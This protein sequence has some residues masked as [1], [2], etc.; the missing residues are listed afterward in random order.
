MKRI[1]KPARLTADDAARHPGFVKSRGFVRLSAAIQGGY[2]RKY[3]RD[4]AARQAIVLGTLIHN[5][6]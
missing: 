6:K 2:R 5:G 4:D 3:R 1:H